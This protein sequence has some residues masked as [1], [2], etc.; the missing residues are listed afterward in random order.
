[1]RNTL[2]VIIKITKREKH[3]FNRIQFVGIVSNYRNK[4]NKRTHLWMRPF[5]VFEMD[6]L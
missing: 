1:M 6:Y 3:I 2:Y 5:V 4:M